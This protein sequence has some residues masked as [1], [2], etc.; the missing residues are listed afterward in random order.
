M[1]DFMG[2]L[3]DGVFCFTLVS[4]LCLTFSILVSELTSCFLMGLMAWHWSAVTVALELERLE[5]AGTGVVFKTGVDSREDI[6][7]TDGGI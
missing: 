6:M 4:E 1:I 2:L 3:V 5:R 7:D